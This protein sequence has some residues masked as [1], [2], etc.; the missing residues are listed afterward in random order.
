MNILFNDFTS[1]MYSTNTS[2]TETDG[3]IAEK[4]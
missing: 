2:E 3:V 1:G 4:C